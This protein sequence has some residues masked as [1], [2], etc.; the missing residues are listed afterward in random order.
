MNLGGGADE[1]EQFLGETDESR[2]LEVK[3]G[4]VL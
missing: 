2:M 1:I 4:Y 3:D